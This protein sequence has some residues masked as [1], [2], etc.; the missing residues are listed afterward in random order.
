MLLN[1][2]LFAFGA[3]LVYVTWNGDLDVDE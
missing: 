3:F 1:L 2:T